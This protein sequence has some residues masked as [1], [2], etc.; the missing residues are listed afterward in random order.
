M[1]YK[2]SGAISTYIKPGTMVLVMEENTAP[3]QWPLG[4][5]YEVYPGKDGV[6]RVVSI[7]TARGIVKRAITKICI[8][9][10]HDAEEQKPDAEST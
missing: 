6:I 10:I 2:R 9:P 3:L 5:I 1:R 8:L 7:K 4:R